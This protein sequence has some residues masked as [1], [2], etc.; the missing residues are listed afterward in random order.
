MKDTK[1]DQDTPQSISKPKSSNRPLIPKRP[2]VTMPEIKIGVECDGLDFHTRPEQVARDKSRDRRLAAEGGRKGQNDKFYLI[3]GKRIK[4]VRQSACMTQAELADTV[5]LRRVSITNIE[6]GNQKPRVDTIYAVA[7]ALG[8]QVSDILTNDI[9]AM[10][11]IEKQL[12]NCV[13]E[14]RLRGGEFEII[15]HDK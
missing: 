8:V 5:G 12:E 3:L 2:G 7:A 6:L 11:S 9:Q 4:R 13:A 1:N 10:L 15:F 14:D